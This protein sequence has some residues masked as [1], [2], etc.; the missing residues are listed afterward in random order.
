M[1]I[2]RVDL[3]MKNGDVPSFFVSLPDGMVDFMENPFING[4]FRGTPCKCVIYAKKWNHWNH[5]IFEV[6]H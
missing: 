1:A 4:W 6:F 5:V 2:K 3:A